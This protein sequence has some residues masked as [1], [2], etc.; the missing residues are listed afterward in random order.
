M[1][2]ILLCA[3]APFVI[4][5]VFIPI[6]IETRLALGMHP[7]IRAEL[8]NSAMFYREF[9]DA[10]KREYNARAQLLA[11]DRSLQGALHALPPSSALADSS[12][13]SD[14]SVSPSPSSP[15]PS[16]PPP[17]L[18][19]LQQ[20]LG[21]MLANTPEA[22]S[23]RIAGQDPSEDILVENNLA[24]AHV[25]VVPKTIVVPLDNEGRRTLEVTFAL[26]KRYLEQR[27]HA[28]ETAA[29]YSTSVA[30]EDRRAH[31]YYFAYIAIT[32]FVVCIALAS[33]Y[34]LARADTRRIA[35][36]ARATERVAKGE[37]GFTVPI[38]GN[39]E[40]TELSRRFNR[41]IEEVAEARDRIVYLEK[42]SGWQEFAR[43]LAHEIKNPLTPIRLAIQELRQ[44]TPDGN[45]AF[46]KLVEDSA[47]V[48]EEEIR[49][50]TRLVDE[51]SQF[52]RLPEV[53]PSAVDLRVFLQDFLSAYNGFEANAD[54]TLGVPEDPIV[55]PVDRVL[56][57]RV[58]FNLVTNAIQAVGEA[59][60]TVR[61]ACRILSRDWF[62]LSVIDNGPG[63]K[64][65]DAEHIFDPY[66][67]TKPEGTGLGLAIVKKIV[68]QHGGT[69]LLRSSETGAMFVMT[70]PR[71]P[72]DTVPERE[73]SR[74]K[75]TH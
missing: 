58:L 20:R 71:S 23:L 24:Q 7:R 29:L 26:P 66:F 4:S 52:A 9:F 72:P 74:A 69:I 60:A 50:L 42:V 49:T 14:S 13:P 19:T 16:S 18:K 47:D 22:Q 1:L 15:S 57:R 68:L 40:I 11:Q 25:P 43:R 31:E 54:V 3:M 35:R 63:I 56:M 39:D 53:V 44:R 28:E 73:T 70:L 46:R 75:D 36:L 51:F 41:M 2:A 33:G 67:T 21:E 30:T 65:Q 12:R 32:A 62:E 34:F 10:K 6:I 61:I 17:H 55:A 27:A 5:V 45:T 38:R 59:R 48:V 64:T 8:D 37:R